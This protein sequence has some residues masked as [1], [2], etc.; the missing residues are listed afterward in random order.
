MT[1]AL[2]TSH[3]GLSH[4]TG[5]GHPERPARLEALLDLFQTDEIL[6]ALP[7]KENA[8]PASREDAAR[9]HIHAYLNFLEDI[10]PEDDLVMIDGDTVIS[11]ESLEAAYAASGALCQAVQDAAAREITRAFCA[12]RP[13]GHHAEPDRAM[14][15]CLLNH[16]MIAA[17]LAQEECGYKKI[18]IL[19]FDVHHGNGTDSMTHKAENILYISSHQGGIFPGTGDPRG[20][21]PGKILNIVPEGTFESTTFRSLYED[22][23][24]PALTEFSPDLLLI[25]AGFDAHRDDPLAGA[26]L[27]TDDFAWLGERLNELVTDLNIPAIA[28]LEGGYNLD[29]LKES[30]R[31]FCHKLLK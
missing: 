5:P 17:R 4:D 13:P 1:A 22:Q 2:Y 12:V 3:L 23:V 31:G 7:L 9:V 6:S 21:I 24:F 20:N 16:V 18:A 25:S 10:L 29:A 30:A 8:P 28:M 19:D 14:G 11:P 26:L 15:F 27:E